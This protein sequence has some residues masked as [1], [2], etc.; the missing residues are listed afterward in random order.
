MLGEGI[1]L[2]LANFFSIIGA[3]ILYLLTIWIPY[4]NVGTTIA[5]QAIPL[6]LSK[7]RVISPTFIFDSK[8]RRRMGEYFILVTLMMFAMIVGT[9]FGFIPM[10]VI[11]LAWSLAI[12]LFIDK[13]MTPLQALQESNRLTYGNKW[14]IF[15]ISLIISLIACAAIII[16]NALT[17]ASSTQTISIDSSTQTISIAPAATR[18]II[19]ILINILIVLLIAPFTYSCSAIIYKELTKQ[20]AET[21]PEQP[22]AEKAEQTESYTEQV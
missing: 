1:K 17:G 8:Y 13:E 10:F 14:R 9:I 22:I 16:A 11:S 4:I 20:D 12:Y 15:A 2:G 7:G 21:E 19:N 3:T 18:I 5:M 6:E